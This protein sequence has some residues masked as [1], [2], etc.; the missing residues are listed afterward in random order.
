MDQPKEPSTV[1]GGPELSNL[2]DDM[3]QALIAKVKAE[4]DRRMQMKKE[5]LADVKKTLTTKD[6][7]H[8]KQ[9][10]DKLLSGQANI[11]IKLQIPKLKSTKLSAWRKWREDFESY[12]F[13]SDCQ[14]LLH[15]NK[16][17]TESNNQTFKDMNTKL[18]HL[19]HT[20]MP[21]QL[22]EVMHLARDDGQKA[23]E[24]LEKHQA[25]A[26]QHRVNWLHT[27][28]DQARL[29][30]G[31]NPTELLNFLIRLY[32]E[33]EY[34]GEAIT[35]TQIQS[36][37]LSK[38]PEDYDHF[39]EVYEDT[40]NTKKSLIYLSEQ[41]TRDYV[42][43]TCRRPEKY[44]KQRNDPG[45]ERQSSATSAASNRTRGDDWLQNIKCYNCNQ[46]GHFAKHCPRPDKRRQSQTSA[47]HEIRTQQE[48]RRVNLVCEKPKQTNTLTQRLIQLDCGCD[49]HMFYDQCYFES[50][51]QRSIEIEDAAEQ[52][53][54]T[55]SN[56]GTISIQT[57]DDK[58]HDVILTISEVLLAQKFR[59]NLLSVGQLEEKGV[60]FQW[61]ERRMLLPDGSQIPILKK[62]RLYFIEIAQQSAE[63]DNASRSCSSSN[64]VLIQHQRFGHPGQHKAEL[65]KT[66]LNV[67]CN[68][69]DC[70]V[71]A[72][73]KS[74][75]LPFKPGKPERRAK[76]FLER[77]SADIAEVSTVSI[78]GQKYLSGFVDHATHLLWTYPIKKKS[79]VYETYNAFT[80]Q[81][82]KPKSLR[83]DNEYIKREFKEKLKD[84]GT[85]HQLT[86]PY[87]SQQNADIET[88]WRVLFQTVRTNLK[89]A[90]LPKGY[91]NYAA[92]Y[93]TV[94]HNAWPREYEDRRLSTP[95]EEAF[96]YKPRI[97]L[98]KTF[99][100]KAFVH[101][102]DKHRSDNKLSSRAKE[103]IFLGL[104]SKRK[105]YKVL[106]PETNRLVTSPHVTFNEN[107]FSLSD[108]LKSLYD[109][110]V[111]EYNYE[112]DNDDTDD[113]REEGVEDIQ[114]NTEVGMVHMQDESDDVDDDNANDN[115]ATPT[116]KKGTDSESLNTSDTHYD[117]DSTE[118]EL[119]DIQE[120]NKDHDEQNVNDEAENVNPRRST[121]R[122]RQP[123]EWWRATANSAETEVKKEELYTPNGFQDA[124]SCAE[125]AK[126]RESM[127]EEVNSLIR[128]KTWKVVKRPKNTNV[129]SCKWIYKIKFNADGCV[130]RYKS[131]LVAR[132][133][134][135]KYGEDYFETFSPVATHTSM[136]VLLAIAAVRGTKLIKADITTAF[137]EAMLD[138]TI[139]MEKPEGVHIEGAGDDHVLLL[140]KSI[141]G[142][143]QAGRN[144]YGT[145][146]DWIIQQNFQ[147]SDTDTCLFKRGKEDA[148]LVNVDDILAAIADV[149]DRADFKQ[150]LEKRFSLGTYEDLQWHLGMKVEQNDAGISISQ[151]LFTQQIIDA[152]N[153]S[154]ARGC[155]T[156]H[157][158]TWLQPTVDK[159]EALLKDV[160][161]RSIVGSNMYLKEMTRPDI[162]FSTHQLSK[163]VHNPSKVHWNA[164]KKVVRYLIN[165]K[166]LGIFYP[167]D[168][169]LILHGYADADF[170]NDSSRKSTTGYVFFLGKCPVSWRTQLQ[171]IITT[172]TFEAELVATF[173]AAK[174]V[175]FLRKLLREFNI[176]CTEPTIIKVDNQAVIEVTKNAKQHHRTKHLDVKV[177]KLREWIANGDLQLRYISTKENVAD[178]FTKPLIGKQFEYL[179]SKLVVDFFN[180][181]LPS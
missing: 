160:P 122:R 30:E 174:E 47:A 53:I 34:A 58:G 136:R 55:S 113:E 21:R 143:K 133:F 171:R 19:V 101:V 6:D 91:W 72:K 27:K 16:S 180:N 137:L 50:M 140:L 35:E 2:N 61:N 103:G 120:E 93:S 10:A 128:N 23:L 112:D 13:A 117:S 139:Y 71:C 25:V 96:K 8:F 123:G 7:A 42:R 178:V 85:H 165:T 80:A 144:W 36:K 87:S 108:T 148:L 181:H 88:K 167:K 172:S 49:Q 176:D 118:E 106:I 102:D 95:F 22:Q 131:R 24:L 4:E 129:V 1:G 163:F 29:R 15:L 18:Y 125:S 170:A 147:K 135:Q 173:E 81:V 65:I 83:T 37:L 150:A 109:Y 107:D 97:E 56:E 146:A 86:C 14:G 51:E 141:Y 134:T 77:V 68:V 48:P 74:R 152:Y 105:G 162:C 114:S 76:D 161:Y 12:L 31:Q 82:G 20:A 121:R 111:S 130:D 3:L 46:Y 127:Q 115:N 5:E 179:K 166:K 40:P 138:E 104:S 66:H 9:N 92:K 116:D 154:N 38:L 60:M 78:K 177:Y 100:C 28:I 157:E 159:S 63:D 75:R 164:A 62:G 52:T 33:L 168:N 84:E 79:D 44:K 110:E 89:T 90:R 45:N 43:K 17:K 11:K 145:L 126:W 67:E 57:K 41:L 155:M 132:G 64:R 158:K 59:R 151:P 149:Q 54:D 169:K 119:K 26:S 156:P 94:Q 73:Q 153:M 98:L 99:G 70:E 69:S 175:L 32:E 142:L 39:I 124:I